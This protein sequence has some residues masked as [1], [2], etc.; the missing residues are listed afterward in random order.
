MISGM[1]V[2]WKFINTRKSTTTTTHR[3]HNHFTLHRNVG[4]M[5]KSKDSNVCE[6]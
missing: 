3:G 1:G 4:T 6:L 5:G 2:G